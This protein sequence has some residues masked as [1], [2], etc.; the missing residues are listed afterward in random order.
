MMTA[1]W[2]E[3]ERNHTYSEGPEGKLLNGR[4]VEQRPAWVQG[5][6][7]AHYGPLE[8]WGG[9]E[10]PLPHD[11]H[12]RCI[13]RGRPPYEGPAVW[14]DMPERHKGIMWQHAPHGARVDPDADIVAY[15]I[16]VA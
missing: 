9:G 4:R 7:L 1:W 2:K 13:F 12:V 16:K 11:V 15:Q 10:C 8:P 14:P 3:F 6:P 5:P